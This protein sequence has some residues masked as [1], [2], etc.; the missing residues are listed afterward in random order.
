MSFYSQV[1]TEN[2]SGGLSL[3]QVREKKRKK[4]LFSMQHPKLS[5][6]KPVTSI[7]IDT[8]FVQCLI[9]HMDNN[10]DDAVRGVELNS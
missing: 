5:S 8:L 1:L 9:H 2:Y 3:N 10:N 7:I 4:Y 6:V